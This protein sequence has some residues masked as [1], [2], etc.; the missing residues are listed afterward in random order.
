MFKPEKVAKQVRYEL[1]KSREQLKR[2]L[3]ANRKMKENPFLSA[4]EKHY[5]SFE[6]I[7]RNDPK[8]GEFGALIFK[9]IGR[10]GNV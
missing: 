5:A 7:T 4:R 3:E 2:R 9:Q 8:I 10:G 1:R 6:G